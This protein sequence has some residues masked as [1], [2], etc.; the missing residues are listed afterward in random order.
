MTTDEILAFPF[1]DHGAP[2]T[3]AVGAVRELPPDEY[4]KVCGELDARLATLEI[5]R[6]PVAVLVGW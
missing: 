4:A 3:E 5:V 6:G 1:V 2:W